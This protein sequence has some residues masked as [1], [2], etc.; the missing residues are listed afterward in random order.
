MS[1]RRISPPSLSIRSPISVSWFRCRV[2]GQGEAR[3]SSTASTTATSCSAAPASASPS[4]ANKVPGIRAALTHDTYSA[5][6]GREVEQRRT[7]ITMG[8]RVIGPELAKAIV[9]PWLAS[10]FDPELG[11]SAGNVQAIDKLDAEGQL[12]LSEYPAVDMS[13]ADGMMTT[14][15]ACLRGTREREALSGNSASGVTF[16]RL[17]TMPSENWIYAATSTVGAL[18]SQTG[19]TAFLERSQYNAFQLPW[20]KSTHQ[21]A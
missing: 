17:L 7:I 13:A 1:L 12:G 11:P 6:P 18:S 15:L 4:P 9:D 20:R 5:E 8:A 21:A 10:E 16:Y 3:K 14:W 19:P 2:G